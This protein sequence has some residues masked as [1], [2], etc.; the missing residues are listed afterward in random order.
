MFWRSRTPDAVKTLTARLDAVERKE[1]LREA[2]W[3]DV[4]DRFDRLYKRIVARL[5]RE[6]RNSTGKDVPVEPDAS[7]SDPGESTLA[8]RRR[9]R[10]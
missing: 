3:L 9:L 5:D 2:E 7:R 1:A 10:G 8:L 4:L 6:R